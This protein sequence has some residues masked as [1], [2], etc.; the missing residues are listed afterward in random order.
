MIQYIDLTEDED[1]SEIEV[2]NIGLLKEVAETPDITGA[3]LRTLD[4][5]SD[6]NSIRSKGK[7]FRGGELNGLFDVS[8]TMARTRRAVRRKLLILHVS[9]QA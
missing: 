2:C 6:G 7:H 9:I 5:K 8:Q 3:K 1:A 4:T